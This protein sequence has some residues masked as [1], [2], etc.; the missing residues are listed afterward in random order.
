[1]GFERNY[2]ANIPSKQFN[3]S[4]LSTFKHTFINPW[5]ITGL[6]D[7]EGSF[8][9][10]IDKNKTRKSPTLSSSQKIDREKELK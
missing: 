5:V 7:S 6:I 3:I 9:I 4:K 8:S 1:M 2:R 10:I